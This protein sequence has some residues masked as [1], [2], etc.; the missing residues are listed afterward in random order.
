MFQPVIKI[1]EE[2]FIPDFYI[3]DL[4][5]RMSIYKRISSINKIDQCKEIITEIIDRFG[6]LPN[7]VENLFKVIEI[8]IICL[9]NNINFIEF[10]RKGIVLGF[11]K[12]NPKNP[13]KIMKLNISNKQITI[14]SD[15]KIFYDLFGELNEDRFVLIKKIIQEI[16]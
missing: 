15:Q 13:E 14:R 1:P 2:I 16:I 12:N 5:L 7:Q 9:N 10:N 3:D 11:Y 8:K 6:K 4:D